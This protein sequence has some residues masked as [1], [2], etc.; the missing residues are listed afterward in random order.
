LERKRLEAVCLEK[1]AQFQNLSD[2]HPFVITGLVPV[3]P[4]A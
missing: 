2:L 4:I 1:A 3:I